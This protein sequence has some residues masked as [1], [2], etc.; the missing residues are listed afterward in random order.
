MTAT[1]NDSISSTITGMRKYKKHSRCNPDYVL[2]FNRSVARMISELRRG[3]IE[4]YDELASKEEK[5]NES[6]IRQEQ[7]AR[8]SLNRL[9]IGVSEYSTFAVDMLNEHY[10]VEYIDGCDTHETGFFLMSIASCNR[11][12][13]MSK[14]IVSQEIGSGKILG[15]NIVVKFDDD[16]CNHLF[17]TNG[18]LVI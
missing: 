8:V 16:N 15:Y 17:G 13:T 10:M 18:C 11:F 3:F 1:Q 6:L 9:Q 14:P 2:P 7:W 4:V 5:V 12:Q